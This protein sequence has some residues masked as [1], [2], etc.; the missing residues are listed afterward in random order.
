MLYTPQIIPDLRAFKRILKYLKR[1]VELYIS[2]S[3]NKVIVYVSVYT[4]SVV[5]TYH[6]KGCIF[7]CIC[8][9]PC[10][11]QSMSLYHDFAMIQQCIEYIYIVL[12]KESHR[13]Y[14]YNEYVAC[15]QSSLLENIN[16]WY[17]VEH[18]STVFVCKP[19]CC[20]VKTKHIYSDKGLIIELK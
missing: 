6:Y 1:L 15:S 3:H 14:C 2:H 11:V 12:K 8:I 5:F 4:I 20:T 7:S 10:N 18:S 9:H 13:K 16:S 19:W 17:V